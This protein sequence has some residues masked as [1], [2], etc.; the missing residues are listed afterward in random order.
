[1]ALLN[2]TRTLS[3]QCGANAKE[4]NRFLSHLYFRQRGR[5]E[6]VSVDDIRKWELQLKC[7]HRTHCFGAISYSLFL[8]AFWGRHTAVN[9]RRK[10]FAWY[11]LWKL[12]KINDEK[13]LIHI[14]VALDLERKLSDTLNTSE[15]SKIVL[16]HRRL[17]LSIL[18]RKLI[19]ER[20]FF[21]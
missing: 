16:H 14:L 8:L 10:G 3:T 2:N 11:N 1:M 6:C 15:R 21:Y 12:F 7:E 9:M 18:E 5:C 4:G 19:F 17:R 20:T 13:S